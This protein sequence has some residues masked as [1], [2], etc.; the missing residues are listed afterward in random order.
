[1]TLREQAA[2]IRNRLG[3]IRSAIRDD[4]HAADSPVQRTCNIDEQ[5]SDDMDDMVDVRDLLSRYTVDQLAEAADGCYRTNT[6]AIDYFFAKPAT[7]VD[8][9]T[10][11]LT[12]FAQ[13]LAGV[14]PL[15]GMRVL[16]FG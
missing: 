13:V 11:I 14:R 12:C 5:S 7:N 3:A 4:S 6:E 8:E 9:A 15:A 10:E 16:D 2:R 1:M